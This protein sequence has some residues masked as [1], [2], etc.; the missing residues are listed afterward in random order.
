MLSPTQPAR[1]AR[2]TRSPQATKGRACGTRWRGGRTRTATALPLTLPATVKAINPLVDD[3]QDTDNVVRPDA[4]LSGFT[5]A[6][7]PA[8]PKAP[9]GGAP[10]HLP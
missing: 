4:A 9:D 7:H 3:W 6:E 2:S 10:P 8:R 5:P 1:S